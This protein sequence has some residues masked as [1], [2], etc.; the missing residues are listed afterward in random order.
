MIPRS[1]PQG[2][3]PLDLPPDPR[4]RRVSARLPFAGPRT[5]VALMLREMS[6]T[7][8]RSPGGYL[9]AVL[10]P[11]LG[12]ALLSLVFSLG[13]RAPRLGTNFAIF[14]ATGVLPF[15]FFSILSGRMALAILYSQALL[16]YPRVTFVDVLTARFVLNVLTQLLVATLI[17]TGIRLAFDTRTTLEMSS[18]MLSFAMAGVLGAGI[19]TLN[20]FLNALFPLWDRAW[21]IATRPLFLLSGVIFIYESIP[22]PYR[23]WLWYNPLMHVTGEMRA[24]FYYG[25]EAEYVNPAYVFAIGLTCLLAGLIFLRRYHRDIREL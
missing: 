14:Y 1:G 16:A 18:I 19:G 17:F 15:Q 23:G 2:Q 10:E 24:G 22:E 9:W 8:G 13:F 11:V 12:I 5:I 4:L 20:C 25:Y 7:Y 6:S 3:P 21:S